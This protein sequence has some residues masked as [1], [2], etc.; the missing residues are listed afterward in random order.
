MASYYTVS[1]RANQCAA[2]YYL[3]QN[4]GELGALW[5]IHKNINI[6]IT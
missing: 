4:I 2:K 5:L 1:Q 6:N 3:W